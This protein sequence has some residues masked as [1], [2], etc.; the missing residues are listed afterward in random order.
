MSSDT[1][2]PV[3]CQST[4]YSHLFNTYSNEQGKIDATLFAEISA[5]RI[6]MG[7]DVT[8]LQIQRWTPM[9]TSYIDSIVRESG[10]GMSAIV[11]GT[12]VIDQYLAIVFE[13]SGARYDVGGVCRLFLAAYVSVV[14]LNDGESRAPSWTRI[15]SEE[16]ARLSATEKEFHDLMKLTAGIERKSYIATYVEMMEAYHQLEEAR[17]PW[18]MRS[19]RKTLRNSDSSKTF[20]TTT[21]P[22]RQPESIPSCISP[23]SKQEE[24]QS[25]KVFRK[26]WLSF[27]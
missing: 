25:S 13:E 18:V 4:E 3:S 12:A 23:R 8:E 14:M 16:F 11:V 21:P 27:M 2:R 24:S 1:A 26:R 22:K 10:R 19:P 7:C 17:T 5:K 9:F 15:T 20:D 6:I